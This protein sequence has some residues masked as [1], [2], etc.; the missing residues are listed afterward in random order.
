[1]PTTPG[2]SSSSAPTRENTIEVNLDDVEQ[3]FNTMDPSPFHHKDLDHDLEE[4]IMSWAT[5]YPLNEPLRLVVYLQNRPASADAQSVIEH[6]VH[7]YF[8]YRTE[9][10]YREFKLLLR[11]GRLSLLI[12]LLFLSLCLS[13][14]QAAKRLEIPGATIVEASLTIAGWVAMWHP[15]D[16]FLYGWWPIRREGKVYRKLSAVPVEVRYSSVASSSS[17]F[18]A[19]ASARDQACIQ[20]T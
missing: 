4:F 19:H 11:E 1:M 5:E 8:A 16:V 12:G 15:M 7:N 10:N 13:A 6:A 20:I 14:A 3:F 18:V 9:L 17:K 2:P